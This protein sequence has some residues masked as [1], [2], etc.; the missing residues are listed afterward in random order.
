M[1]DVLKDRTLAAP[2]SDEFRQTRGARPEEVHRRD[3]RRKPSEL[4]S[5]IRPS[6]FASSLSAS[7][8]AGS[9]LGA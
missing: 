9:V 1:A 3:G 4:G 7:V 2:L 5:L 8:V 6:L